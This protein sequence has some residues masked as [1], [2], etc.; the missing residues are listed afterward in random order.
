MIDLHDAERGTR[1]GTISD[2]QLQFLA[3]A[4]EEES[5]EDKDYYISADTIDMLEE[6]G[7]DRQLLQILRGALGERE[8]MDVRWSSP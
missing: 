3:D 7:A 5:L 2:E 6:D 8:G 1:L 4:L